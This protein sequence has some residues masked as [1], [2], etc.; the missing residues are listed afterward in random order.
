MKGNMF[1]YILVAI[2]IFTLIAGFQTL[3]DA[4][5]AIHETVG[6]LTWVIS[7]VCFAGYGIIAAIEKQK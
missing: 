2:A 1:K 7:A 3:S 4:K 5:S 6:I